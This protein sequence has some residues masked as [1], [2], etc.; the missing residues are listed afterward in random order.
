[1]AD[2]S[3]FVRYMLAQG[4]K[5]T[6]NSRG[7]IRGFRSRAGAPQADLSRNVGSTYGPLLTGMTPQS[8]WDSLFRNFVTGETPSSMAAKRTAGA[9]HTIGGGDAGGKEG[10]GLNNSFQPGGTLPV[11]PD[12]IPTLET[13][14]QGG[15][16][17]AQRWSQPKAL[18]PQQQNAQIFLKYGTP[19]SMVDVTT[20]S[21]RAGV[22]EKTSVHGYKFD[23][24]QPYDEDQNPSSFYRDISVSKPMTYNWGNAFQTP[25]G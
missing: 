21:S 2:S 9:T 4:R 7:D 8:N 20:P 14:A 10:F 3:D 22:G 23:P 1:M 13:M 6:F 18:T 16:N 19:G 25:N 24:S 12:E 5:P 11:A 17:H 15:M